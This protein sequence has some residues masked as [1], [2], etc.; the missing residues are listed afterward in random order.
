MKGFENYLLKDFKNHATDLGPVLVD[1]CFW[2]GILVLNIF[3]SIKNIINQDPKEIWQQQ[4]SIRTFSNDGI[5]I[6]NANV[7]LSASAN[8]DGFDTSPFDSYIYQPGQPGFRPAY[9]DIMDPD[10]GKVILK[11][12]VKI[13]I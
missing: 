2:N 10:F 11:C 3:A 13:K 7:P 9:A 1:T 8:F 4:Q 5:G 12:F 6:Q